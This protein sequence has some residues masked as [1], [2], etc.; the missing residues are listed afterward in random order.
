[1]TQRFELRE[2]ESRVVRIAASAA[3]DIE[4]VA[5]G[6]IGVGIGP[7]AGTWVLSAGGSVG[8]VVT[9]EVEVLVRPKIPLHNLFLLL[10]I[11]LPP[12]AWQ[13]ATF[14]FRTDRNLLAAMA[15]FFAR[16]AEHA[17]GRGIR[18]DYRHE[19]DDVVALRGRVDVVG[20]LRRPGMVSPIACRFDEYTAD[21][22]ENRALKA[23]ARRLL[24]L[25]GVRPDARR[26][27]ERLLVHLGEASDDSVDPSAID[28]VSFTRL[29]RHYEPALRLAA[30]VLRNTSLI[31]R[32]GAADASAFFLDMPILF[33][34]WLTRRLTRHL[35]SRLDLIAEPRVYLGQHHTVPMAPDLVFHRPR[36]LAVYAGDVKYKLTSDARGRNDDY[37]QLFAYLTALDLP[38][39]VLVYC[40]GDGA[41]ER[42]VV[43]RHVGARL[44]TYALSLYGSPAEVEAEVAELASWIVSRVETPMKPADVR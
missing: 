40:Q 42:E 43:V 6:K 4:E 30:L 34:R 18:R 11:G 25:P 9:P 15:A 5:A 21:I 24:R 26:M 23:A 35:R 29:N 14:A 8:T 41:P 16:T 2:Y 37:Y 22:D 12:D 36:G 13:P 1:M 32:V 44:R 19:E 28:R 27:L 7:E 38:E 39:G 3:R 10:D 17:L 20:Q 33:Q 31:D